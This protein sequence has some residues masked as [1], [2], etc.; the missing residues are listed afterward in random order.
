MCVFNCCS[1]NKG[2]LQETGDSFASHNHSSPHLTL[3]HTHADTDCDEEEMQDCGS[4][5]ELASV[6][7]LGLFALAC[8]Y[9]LSQTFQEQWSQQPTQQQVCER[10]LIL[11]CVRLLCLI[12]VE[13]SAL[14]THTDHE[15][16]SCVQFLMCL[17]IFLTQV[18]TPKAMTPT[19]FT[20]SPHLPTPSTSVSPPTQ[21]AT[22]SPS[23]L[24]LSSPHTQLCPSPHSL[25]RTPVSL[26][27]SNP[28]AISTS[29]QEAL[30]A[31]SSS[32]V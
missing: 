8:V 7:L 28:V 29:V 21:K 10:G 16:L 14:K 23:A 11:L 24:S 30:R 26:T 27:R 19:F 18:H 5:N 3:I 25:T 13:A 20:S 31:D 4:G 22:H 1:V 15:S 12:V 9:G 17:F 32:G 2:S 6:L